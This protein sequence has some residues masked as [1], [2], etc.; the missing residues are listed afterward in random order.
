MTKP[1]K[2]DAELVLIFF[3]MIFSK[4]D[5]RKA[6]WWWVEKPA[7]TSFEEFMEKYPPGSEGYNNFQ[8]CAS[9]FEMIGILVY[10]GLLHEELAFDSFE[11][12]WDKSEPIVKGMRI[13]M[14]SRELSLYL[15]LPTLPLLSSC[16]CGTLSCARDCA[17]PCWTTW[18]SS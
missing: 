6:F 8:V 18:V 3:R 9:L 2:D 5:V 13:A 1:T 16:T 4:E 12:L 17:A 11:L 7:V 14:T 10:H 15:T